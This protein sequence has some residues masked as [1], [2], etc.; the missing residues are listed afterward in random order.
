MGDHGHI[1]TYPWGQAQP[2]RQGPRAGTLRFSSC[3]SHVLSLLSSGSACRSLQLTKTWPAGQAVAER[4]EGGCWKEH[5]HSARCLEP[6][7]LEVGSRAAGL[8][9]EMRGPSIWEMQGELGTDT[10]WCP[11]C[12]WTFLGFPCAHPMWRGGV[13]GVP[14]QDHL[15]STSPSY[16]TRPP[17]QAPLPHFTC[18]FLFNPVTALG[19]I[20]TPMSPYN[21]EKHFCLQK[22]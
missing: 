21:G 17:C 13:C 20:L 5:G 11:G 15:L 12:F 1:D 22:A 6:P 18:V 14:Q 16:Q 2:E 7:G 3:C 4:G 19:G 10:F 9:R 8:A